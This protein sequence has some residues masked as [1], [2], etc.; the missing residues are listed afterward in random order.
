MFPIGEYL[1]KYKE[2]Q[3]LTLQPNIGQITPN[4]CTHLCRRVI[5]ENRSF[6]HIQTVTSTRLFLM[7]TADEMNVSYYL[8]VLYRSENK[9]CS[10]K[11]RK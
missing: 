9:V 5:T 7:G 4:W 8:P 3:F 11:E 2:K 10:S 1:T 6:L